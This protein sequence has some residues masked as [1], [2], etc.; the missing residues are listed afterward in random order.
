[1]SAACRPICMQVDPLPTDPRIVWLHHGPQQL[2]LLPALGGSVAAWRWGHIDL[3]RPWDGH[4]DDAYTL[5]SFPLVPWSNRIGRGGFEHQGRWHAVLPNRSGEPYPIHGDGWLQGWAL[6]RRGDGSAVLQLESR[7][8]AGNPH[9]YRAEQQFTLVDGGLDQTL[10]VTHLG[11]EPLPYGLGQHPYF[12]V[13]GGVRLQ[14][15]VQGAWLSGA[16]PMPT[17][18]TTTL[19][20]GWDLNT[21]IDAAEGPLIDNGYT[22]FG[23][24]ATIR[25]PERACTLQM[26]VE[27]LATPHGPVPAA[28]CLLYRP[29]RGQ[30]FAFE[31]ITH[32]IDAFHLDQRPGLVVLE[33][34]QTLT[35]TVRWRVGP[36][37]GHHMP[38]Q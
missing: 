18:H 38:G 16:D 15:G 23:G 17:A 13:A 34:G 9:H 25:W 3:W 2:G 1:M 24:Q 30:A 33:T 4:S 35:M 19:P 27:P 21:G 5:A 36:H 6:E 12:P 10:G 37:V 8:H 20:S 11:H 7:G 32:P 28:Y 26:S 29:G 31:P 14:A 22:G